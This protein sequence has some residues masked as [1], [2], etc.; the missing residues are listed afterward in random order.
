[1][2]KLAVNSQ[3]LCATRGDAYVTKLAQ[4]ILDSYAK[5]NIQLV[6]PDGPIWH[7]VTIDQL[8]ALL[9]EKTVIIED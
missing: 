5:R 2:S 8:K 3:R 7:P 1:M 4:N 9:R 6:Q